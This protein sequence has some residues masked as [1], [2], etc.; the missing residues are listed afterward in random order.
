MAI[1]HA[2]EQ[3]KYLLQIGVGKEQARAILPL[4]QYTEVY[5]TASFQAIMNFIELRNEKTSQWEIQ[6]YA[7]ELLSLMHEVYPMT[8]KLWSEAHN[9]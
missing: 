9:W 1:F 8:T 6:E 4:N 3:Y 2:K 7:R 5:W